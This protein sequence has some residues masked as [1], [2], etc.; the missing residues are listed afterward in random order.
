MTEKTT[1]KLVEELHISWFGVEGTEDK[2]MI[3]YVKE[4]RE[5]VQEFRAEVKDEINS[6]N[7]RHNK[8]SNK[9]WMIIGVLSVSGSGAGIWKL[10]N[11]LN[12]G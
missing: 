12:G 4:T 10:V 8:L 1:K 2:G 3:E 7:K 6:V 11:L 9:V 5:E